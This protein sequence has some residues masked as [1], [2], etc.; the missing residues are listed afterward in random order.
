LEV[1]AI[2]YVTYPKIVQKNKFIHI[3]NIYMC[4]YTFR[5]EGRG[6]EWR[7]GREEREGDGGERGTERS[8]WGKMLITSELGN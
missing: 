7:K 5:R 1:K 2:M 6:E 3:Q 8:K 4:T